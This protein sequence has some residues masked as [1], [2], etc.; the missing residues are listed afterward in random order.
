MRVGTRTI[1]VLL[2]VMGCTYSLTPPL[3]YVRQ[4]N[5]RTVSPRKP[6]WLPPRKMRLASQPQMLMSL[7]DIDI[8]AFIGCATALAPAFVALSWSRELSSLR[9][10]LDRANRR[11]QAE[12]LKCMTSSEMCDPT[13]HAAATVA[14]KLAQQRLDNFW[15]WGR[16]VASSLDGGDLESPRGSRTLTPT[17]RLSA[18]RSKDRGNAEAERSS[19]QSLSLLS[20]VLLLNVAIL[21]GVQGVAHEHAAWAESMIRESASHSI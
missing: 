9:C 15:A 20:V 11:L 7:S 3:S 16:R 2:G 8:P 6:T 19:L 5:L 1:I 4:A 21:A 17:M 18:A 10:A 13:A 14:V 12:N